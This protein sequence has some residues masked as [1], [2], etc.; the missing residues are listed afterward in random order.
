MAT[1]ANSVTSSN[2]RI[3]GSTANFNDKVARFSAPDVQ[4]TATAAGV[5]APTVVQK[6]ATPSVLDAN[7]VDPSSATAT[8]AVLDPKNP[9]PA[10]E[11]SLPIGLERFPYGSGTGPLLPPPADAPHIL[12]GIGTPPAAAQLSEMGAANAFSPEWQSLLQYAVGANG[13]L[14]DA[15]NGYLAFSREHGFVRFKH[16]GFT[17]EQNRRI[18]AMSLQ[19][20]W[21]IER[22]PGRNLDDDVF[23]EP[24]V[25]E[26]VDG[27]IAKFDDALRTFMANPSEKLVV[28]DGSRNRYMMQFDPASNRVFSGTFRKKGGFSGFV[29]KNFKVIGPVLDGLAVVSAAFGAPYL[30]AGI[31]AAKQGAVSAVTGKFTVAQ[32]LQI[33][34]GF[35]GGP[36]ADTQLGQLLRTPVGNAAFRIGADLAVDGKVDVGTLGGIVLPQILGD[37]P[38][39]PEVGL[40]LTRGAEIL[41]RKLDGKDIGLEQI[42]FAL[43]PVVAGLTRGDD[44]AKVRQELAKA[45]VLGDPN[46][47]ETFTGLLGRAIDDPEDIAL[48][49]GGLSTLFRYLDTGKLDASQAL[50]ILKTYFKDDIDELKKMLK[51]K[52]E[53]NLGFGI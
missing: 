4:R 2:P 39:G 34:G 18:A 15:E 40:A 13:G 6:A 44:A 14:G 49:S 33:A 45:G 10:Q 12:G 24:K 26:W 43:E 9:P 1:A 23:A 35:L 48:V 50:D 21:P 51:S 28:K 17:P 37:L 19:M 47:P 7:D 5:P 27:F 36:L 11:S 22:L 53:T 29:E 46:D 16:P 3:L 30:A 41:A 20:G 25:N 32:G 38:G 8:G 42:Y 52:L 31:Q